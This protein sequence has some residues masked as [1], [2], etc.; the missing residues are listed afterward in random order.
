MEGI[1]EPLGRMVETAYVN[2]AARAVTAAMVARG[3]KPSVISALMKYQTTERMR[4]TV[5][6]AMDIHGGRAICDGPSNYIQAAYQ[7]V[8]V[9]ITVEGANILTRTLITF[10][11]GALRSHP[12]L[13]K[14]VKAVQDTDPKR[15]LAAFEAAFLG[16]ISFTVGNLFGA[17]FHNLTRGMFAHV[18]EK[19]FGTSDGYR[20]LSRSSRNF[21]VV[22]DLTVALLGGGLKV[23]QKLTGRLADALS[24]LYMLSCV[25]K[26]Y[27]DDGKP[28]ADE[29]IV[30][31]AAQNG[32]YRFQVALRGT[33]ENFPVAW[34]R[35]LMRALVYPLGG[36]YHPAPDSLA[37]EVVRLA[38]EPGEVRDRLTRY[39]FVSKDPDDPTGL[40]EVTMLKVIAAEPAEKKLDR[41]VRDGRIKRYHGIDWIG[42]AVSAKIITES[43]GVLLREVEALTA[44]V[45]AVDH[46]DPAEVRPN[47]M[48]AGHNMRA[49]QTAAE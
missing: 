30:A 33:I 44:R 26:R 35:I 34:A 28:A 36:H 20:Q 49:V 25:L 11:Q 47:F 21:A 10:A 7:T 3:E 45:I 13:Y 32:L 24:E 48:T 29:P 23:K 18:P 22:A 14:E 31:M 15:G 8:P 40:L 12:F 46:F 38:I 39:M 42:D 4:R 17:L 9:G 2:E 6:D 27:E 41:A 43:E 1:E 16:H 37:H 5:N 19:S